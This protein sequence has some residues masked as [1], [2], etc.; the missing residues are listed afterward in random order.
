M[1]TWTLTLS[2]DQYLCN[3]LL[4]I[5]CKHRNSLIE[6]ITMR[7]KTPANARFFLT[8]EEQW[9]NRFKALNWSIS[10]RCLRRE[11]ERQ[12]KEKPC[13]CSCCFCINVVEL[14][15]NRY[16]FCS[17]KKKAFFS[18]SRPHADG[19]CLAWAWLSGDGISFSSFSLLRWLHFIEEKRRCQF[20]SLLYP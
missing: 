11:R 5:I 2:D 15:E 7:T 18:F 6:R 13:D 3:G 20:N 12:G 19:V 1:R 10:Y 16:A 8:G 17:R 9:I 4:Q 14:C